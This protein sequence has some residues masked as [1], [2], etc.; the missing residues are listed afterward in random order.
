M[1]MGPNISLKYTHCNIFISLNVPSIPITTRFSCDEIIFKYVGGIWATITVVIILKA[2]KS[3]DDLVI[4]HKSTRYN[5]SHLNF[6][7]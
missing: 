6:F 5:N 1:K 7:V 4:N 3:K 2:S